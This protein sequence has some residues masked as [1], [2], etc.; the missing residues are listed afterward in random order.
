MATT[1]NTVLEQGATTEV[2]VNPD[3]DVYGIRVEQK[4][5]DAVTFAV[6][7]PEEALRIFLGLAAELAAKAAAA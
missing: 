2:L 5:G 6:P 1:I 3:G 4:N 7:W